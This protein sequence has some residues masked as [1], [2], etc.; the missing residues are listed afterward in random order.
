MRDDVSK[1]PVDLVQL[2][3]FLCRRDHDC[4]L[5][6]ENAERSGEIHFAAGEIVHASCGELAPEAALTELLSWK[7]GDLRVDPAARPPK[8]SLDREV[9][10]R[11][12]DQL[13]L[14]DLSAAGFEPPVLP[15]EPLSLPG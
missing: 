2:V 14:R 7:R 6:L 13:G 5:A 12:L 9:T 8:R 3:G 11:L 10:S 1:Y 4:V 15:R